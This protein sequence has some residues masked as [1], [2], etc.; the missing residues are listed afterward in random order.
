ML[1]CHLG[2]MVLE[3]SC[4][5]NPETTSIKGVLAALTHAYYSCQHSITSET[6]LSGAELDLEQFKRTMEAK[7]YLDDLIRGLSL[8]YFC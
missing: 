7:A 5:T 6:Y 1:L 2:H 8:S 3:V 4:I